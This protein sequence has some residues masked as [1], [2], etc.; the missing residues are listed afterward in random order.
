MGAADRPSSA[1]HGERLGHAGGRGRRIVRAA[2]ILAG[3]AMAVGGFFLPWMHLSA[4][5]EGAPGVGE[6]S[7]WVAFQQGADLVPT[8]RTLAFL[9]PLLVMV[10]ASLALLVIHSPRWR[11]PLTYTSAALAGVFLCL[12][13]F[14]LSVLPTGLAMEWPFYHTEYAYGAWVALAGLVCVALGALV[15]ARDE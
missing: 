6:V 11:A 2:L 4:S 7:P 13:L 8:A 5:F 15:V 9:L 14:V 3:D 10:A 12:A 1:S